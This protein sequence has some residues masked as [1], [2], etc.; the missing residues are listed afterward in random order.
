VTKRENQSTTVE[1]SSGLC[2]PS[3]KTHLCPS[4]HYVSPSC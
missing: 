2:F 3:R 4:L 1:G